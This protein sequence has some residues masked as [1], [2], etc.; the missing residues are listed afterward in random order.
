MTYSYHCHL[1]GP[2]YF[3]SFFDF[4]AEY[5]ARG[6]HT[7]DLAALCQQQTGQGFDESWLAGQTL[8][9][10][11]LSNQLRQHRDPAYQ[12]TSVLSGQPL[13]ALTNIRFANICLF[14]CFF[15]FCCCFLFLLSSAIFF[16]CHCHFRAC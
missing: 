8:I 14:T 12:S 16:L 3:S 15:V 4:T 7:L 1:S 11:A 2:I 5:R 9:F 6:V 13:N 10:V